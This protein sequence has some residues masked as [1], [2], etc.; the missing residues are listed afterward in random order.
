MLMGLE[1]G[2]EKMGK[3]N[4]N[5]NIFMEDTPEDVARKIK[6]AYCEPKMVAKNPILDY[7][8]HIL[9]PS[10][11][12]VEIL[13]EE[14]FGGNKLYNDY[15]SLEADFVQGDLYPDDLKA[16]VGIAINKLL[17][18][19]RHHFATDLYAKSLLAEIKQW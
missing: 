12:H 18:P 14:K 4:S 11:G 10:F 8:K 15:P 7:T 13:R 2:Q 1:K 17:D 5:S 9:F 19:V 6:K 16:A 3:N